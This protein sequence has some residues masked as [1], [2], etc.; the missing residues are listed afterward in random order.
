MPSA[1]AQLDSLAEKLEEAPRSVLRTWFARL[2]QRAQQAWATSD[3][4]EVE[5]RAGIE[6]WFAEASTVEEQRRARL[7]EDG[8]DEIDGGASP[9]RAAGQAP[10]RSESSQSPG[11]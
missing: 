11:W 8:G 9:M 5:A 10:S 4:F 1:R 6:E 7:L 3:N 2:P